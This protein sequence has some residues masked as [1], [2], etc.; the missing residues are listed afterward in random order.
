MADQLFSLRQ[1]VSFSELD[2]VDGAEQLVRL[3]TD[4][5]VRSLFDA[6]KDFEL[7]FSTLKIEVIP[8]ALFEGEENDCL[9]FGASVRGRPKT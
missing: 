3:T 5:V 1:A 7:D 4:Y 9:R 8:W 2:A 6:T